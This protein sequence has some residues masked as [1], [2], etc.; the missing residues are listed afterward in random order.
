MVMTINDWPYHQYLFFELD[1]KFHRLPSTRQRELKRGLHDLLLQLED[2][3]PFIPYTTLG[4]KPGTTF[5]LWLRAGQPEAIQDAV[6]DLLRSRFGQY[7]T[8]TRSLFGISRQSQYTRS[9]QNTD[10]SILPNLRLPYL[11]IYPFTK[12]PDWH[13]MPYDQRHVLMREHISVGKKFPDIRQ[14]LLYAYGVDDHEFIVSY[15]TP[16]LE[17]FQQLVMDMRG[18][19]SR[20]YTLNDLPIYTCIY[21]TPEEFIEWL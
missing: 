6:R 9:P 20:R 12:T 4:F 15:E 7:L 19:E 11:V 2:D 3:V 1:D 21:K 14:C 16:T 18:I 13:L 17:D 10:Q 8:L 5:M